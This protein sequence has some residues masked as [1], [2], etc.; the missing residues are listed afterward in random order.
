MPLSE[1]GS[2]DVPSSDGELVRSGERKAKLFVVKRPRGRP[3]KSQTKEKQRGGNQDLMQKKLFQVSSAGRRKRSFNLDARKISSESHETKEEQICGEYK[4]LREEVERMWNDFIRSDN[5]LMN[6]LRM[7]HDQTTAHI[8]PH[9]RPSFKPTTSTAPFNINERVFNMVIKNHVDDIECLEFLQIFWDRPWGSNVSV[10]IIGTQNQFAQ[11]CQMVQL[12]TNKVYKIHTKHRIDET[13]EQF[14]I[15]K[16]PLPKNFLRK[17]VGYQE[18]ALQY[19]RLSQ[20][21]DVD[22]YFNEKL[23]VDDVFPMDDLTHLRIYGKKS[24]VLEVSQILLNKLECI[25][26]KSILTQKVDCNLVMDNVKEIKSLVDPCEVRI[27]PNER[28]WKDLRHPFLYLPN[29]LRE[30][31]LIGTAD[32]IRVAERKLQGFLRQKRQGENYLVN[33]QLSFLLPIFMR[34]F[35]DKI[36]LSVRKK[37]PTLQIY[38]HLPSFPRK[39]LTVSMIGPWSVILEAKHMLQEL[40]QRWLNKSYTSFDH[41]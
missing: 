4:S 20:K 41:F 16:I 22:F 7:K 1:D 18:K 24:D 10:R 31:I 15:Q 11:I 5:S 32:E 8:P 28:M 23:L 39:H 27:K 25:K 13:L 6:Q 30:I 17:L 40:S 34:D 21:Y 14:E 12:C 36:K 3:K 33:E 9:S 38:H 35:I 26:M 19:F 29:Y 37:Y 2:R